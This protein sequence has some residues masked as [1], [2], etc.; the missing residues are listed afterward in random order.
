MTRFPL[1][2]LPAA[3]GAAEFPVAGRDLAADGDHSRA[4]LKR[5]AFEGAV[6]DVHVLRQ[7]RDGAAVI[8]IEYHEIGIR[9]GLDGTFV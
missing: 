5:P 2:E 7:G 3:E 1:E 4:A 9:A 8:R 6:V